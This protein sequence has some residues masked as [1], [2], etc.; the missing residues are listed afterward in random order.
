MGGGQVEP[1]E[2]VDG[3]R[4]ELRADIIAARVGGCGRDVDRCC[5]KSTGL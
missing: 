4:I 3:A 5:A 1:G 2:N